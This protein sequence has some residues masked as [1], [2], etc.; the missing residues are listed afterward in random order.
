MRALNDPADRRPD[1]IASQLGDRSEDEK[2]RAAV[3]GQFPTIHSGRAIPVT[4]RLPSVGPKTTMDYRYST[5]PGKHR[6]RE[7][8]R[9]QVRADSRPGCPPPTARSLVSLAT[10]RLLARHW[11]KNAPKCRS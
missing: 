2:F 5:E 7:S 9:E 8:T 3:I 4:V 1:L 6:D 10:Q 11:K